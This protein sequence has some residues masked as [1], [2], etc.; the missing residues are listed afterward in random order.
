[1]KKSD[2]SGCWPCSGIK[3]AYCLA[4]SSTG[5]ICK[6]A[7]TTDCVSGTPAAPC[8]DGYFPVYTTATA[9]VCTACATGIKTCT[10][11]TATTGTACFTGYNLVTTSGATNNCPVCATLA[12][13]TTSACG[14]AVGTAYKRGTD[15]IAAVTSGSTT[16]CTVISDADT[17]ANGV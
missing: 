4:A 5:A 14:V 7:G 1:V 11:A 2:N 8:E 15:Y 13:C 10:D 12:A 3:A 17:I 9:V 16:T 6:S